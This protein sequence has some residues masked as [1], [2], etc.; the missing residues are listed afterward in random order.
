MI[1]LSRREAL[2]LL[3]AATVTSGARAAA[4][5]CADELDASS[6]RRNRAL[7]APLHSRK[8]P[9]VEGD[10]LLTNAEAGQSFEEYVATVRAP[11]CR[12]FRRIYLQPIGSF[13]NATRPVV[14]SVIDGLS[15][16]YGL[17]VQPLPAV[18]LGMIPAAA[19]RTF[20]DDARTQL[21]TT[22]LINSILLPRRPPD[23]AS[24]LGLTAHDLWPGEGWNFVFGQSSLADRVGVWSIY[25]NGNPDGSAQQRR[26]FLWRTLK[27]AS[28]ETGHMFGMRHCTRYECGMNGSNSRRESDRQPLEF[29]PECQAKIWWACGVDPKRRL[30]SLLQYGKRQGFTAD[31]AYWR[32][33]LERLRSSST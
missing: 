10:W 9:A 26:Q 5:A 29:C 25:R 12:R 19:R 22:Y 24:V 2:G 33:A 30:A 3:A 14:A 6:L 31:V 18:P 1:R 21:L 11:V 8:K 32:S 15:R 28:H 4:P 13:S 23:A 16:F 7:I 20:S 17:E 27:I